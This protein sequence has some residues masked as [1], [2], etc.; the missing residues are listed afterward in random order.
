MRTV[1]AGKPAERIPTMPQLCQDTAVRIF[2][3]DWIEGVRRCLEEPAV[4]YD[5]VIRLV[6]QIGCDGLRMFVQ[7]APIKTEREGDM[8]YQ[9]NSVGERV[10]RCDLLGGCGMV[11]FA[12]LPR[13]ETLDDARRAVAGRRYSDEQIDRLRQA[14]DRV[15]DLF[16]ASS[17]SGITFDPYTAIQPREAAY[18][19]VLERPEFVHAVFE[20]LLESAIENGESLL[21][22]GI[23]AFYI[24][25]AAASASLISPRHFERFCVPYYQRFCKHFAGRDILIYLHVCGNSKPILE[26]MADTGVHCIE[27][28]DSV[29]GVSVADAK[30]RVGARVVLMGGVNTVLLSRGAPDEVR[31]EAIRC[32]REGGPERYILAAADMIPPDTSLANLQAMVD[33]ATKSQWRE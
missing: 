24:G 21:R 3:P 22:T 9:V 13:L 10:A 8:V 30:R 5:Y 20:L 33:V 28:L 14:R 12:P 29:A 15:P 1:M 17:P 31:A 6:R 23:D 4:I 7:P 26:L 11:P 2:E 18:M 16:V 27:P 25:D 19:D 32:C